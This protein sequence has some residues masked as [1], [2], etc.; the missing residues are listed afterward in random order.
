MAFK[1]VFMVFLILVFLLTVVSYMERL[2]VHTKVPKSPVELD[3]R[4]VCVNYNDSY[5]DKE[6]L[7]TILYGVSAGQCKYVVFRLSESVS[8]GEL[9]KMLGKESLP[10]SNCELPKLDTGSFYY[11]GEEVLE[12]GTLVNVTGR[13]MEGGDVLVCES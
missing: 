13:G 2:Y 8:V 5:V 4:Y 12:E 6:T 1:Y 9:E 11:I 7:E 3:V 10:L